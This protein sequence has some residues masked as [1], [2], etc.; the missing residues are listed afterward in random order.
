MS[1]VYMYLSQCVFNEEQLIS[2]TFCIVVDLFMCN[3][4][5]DEYCTL[6][7]YILCVNYRRK[8]SASSRSHD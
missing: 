7:K 8:R 1:S 4:K 3:I 2:C 5:I 6:C